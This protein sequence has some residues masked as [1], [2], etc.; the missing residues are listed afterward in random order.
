MKIRHIRQGDTQEVYDLGKN[1]PYFV[2]FWPEEVVRSLPN[3]RDVLSLVAE[4]NK[5]IVGFVIAP[6]SET[7][8]KMVVE[9]LFVKD[10]YRIK[11]YEGKVISQHFGDALKIEARRLGMKRLDSLVDGTNRPA[12]RM[13]EKNGFEIHPETYKW[14]TWKVEN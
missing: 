8:K 2:C 3:A 4:E 12:L 7:L 9:N 14:G 1:E 10:N 6:Y 11:L 5:E 13:H